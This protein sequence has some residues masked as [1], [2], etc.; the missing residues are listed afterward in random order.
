MY[1][2]PE[3][4][5]KKKKILELLSLG[6]LLLQ[7]VCSGAHV[8]AGFMIKFW[9]RSDEYLPPRALW[10]TAAFDCVG[11]FF[12]PGWPV[13]PLKPEQTETMGFDGRINVRVAGLHHLVHALA[14]THT[15][16][17]RLSFQQWTADQG[18]CMSD[19]F[20][21]NLRNRQSH[22]HFLIWARSWLVGIDGIK[23]EETDAERLSRW[24]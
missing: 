10:Q 9:L 6:T 3:Q 19:L 18:C 7:L 16:C 12:F 1:A 11:F 15:V 8:S 24:L 17:H 5:K 4:K 22:V 13:F 2:H 21:C 20:I 14:A 23:V